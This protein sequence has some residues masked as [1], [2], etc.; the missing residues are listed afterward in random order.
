LDLR[1]NSLY[2][3][4]MKLATQWLREYHLVLLVGIF[5]STRLLAMDGKLGGALASSPLLLALQVLT[6]GAVVTLLIRNRI[7]TGEK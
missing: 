7:F 6:A 2:N 3:Q 1:E 4:F 5:E